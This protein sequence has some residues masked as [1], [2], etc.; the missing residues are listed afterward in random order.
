MSGPL[1]SVLSAFEGGAGTL[2]EVAARTGLAADVV[3]AAV[4]HLVRLG[5]L[6]AKE[7]AMGC[8]SGGC[9]SCA[10][11][12]AEGTPGC[13]ADAPNPGR[14]GPVLVALTRRR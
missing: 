1:A 5:R 10:S 3:S 8:P 9:G 13:G 6:D 2:A 14:R 11:A 7:L 12:S 4:D